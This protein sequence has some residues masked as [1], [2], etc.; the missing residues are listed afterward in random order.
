[1]GSIYE[2]EVRDMPV[3][4]AVDSK[5]TSVTRPAQRVQKRIAESNPSVTVTVLSSQLSV[6]SCQLSV[7]S[8]QMVDPSAARSQVKKLAVLTGSSRPT[9]PAFFCV[10]TGAGP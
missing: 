1:M 4:V 10:R 7:V 6:V 9:L 2:F 3:T 8:C 5:G